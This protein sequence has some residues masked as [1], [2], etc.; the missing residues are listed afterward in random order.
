MLSHFSLRIVRPN[1]LSAWLW[2]EVTVY[3]RTLPA[4]NMPVIRLDGRHC[5]RL[6]AFR[7]GSGDVVLPMV[8]NVF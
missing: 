5:E 2:G 7:H 6:R 1:S 4:M 8:F 3:R